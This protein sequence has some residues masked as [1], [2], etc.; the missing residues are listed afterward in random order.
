MFWRYYLQHFT[1]M[2]DNGVIPDGIEDVL[3]LVEDYD[4]TTLDEARVQALRAINDFGLRVCLGFR[5]GASIGSAAEW[6]DVDMWIEHADGLVRAWAINRELGQLGVGYEHEVDRRRFGFD[7]EGYQP[8]GQEA[9]V[10]VMATVGVDEAAMR[11][12]MQPLL[13][14]VRT[15]G[16][17]PMI[18][19]A[20]ESENLVIRLIFEASGGQGEL[21]TET[22]FTHGR[23]IYADGPVAVAEERA[24]LMELSAY[25]LSRYPQ[26]QIRPVISDDAVRFWGRTDNVVAS[27][28]RMAALPPWIIDSVRTD[29]S[30]IGTQGWIDGTYLSSLNDAA[31]AWGL[32][33]YAEV[34]A[35]NAIGGD[36]Q[37]HTFSSTGSIS[38]TPSRSVVRD[39][40]LELVA[41]DAYTWGLLVVQDNG[42]GTW[43]SYG[44]PELPTN[45]WTILVDITIPLVCPA[46]CPIVGATTATQWAWL[47][48]YDE[49][50]G[51]VVLDVAYPAAP[52]VTTLN[53]VTAQPG[54]SVRVLIGRNGTTEWRH[55]ASKTVVGGFTGNATNVMRFGLAGPRQSPITT[56]YEQFVGL[57][58]RKNPTMWDRF[59]S[60]S[61]ASWILA[62]ASRVFPFGWDYGV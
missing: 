51:Q 60:D 57:V 3:L 44:V 33:K 22:T 23:H 45:T 25:L 59:I 16:V 4:Q 6:A 11:I 37:L 29:R 12:I 55:G 26:A 50:A 35:R 40:G 15:L 2:L 52:N 62:D 27:I 54:D 49:V 7:C 43:S 13:T 34:P 42:N 53:V 46:F 18:H 39:D 56:P 1:T 31:Y 21:W 28:A 58:L 17:M 61:E 32:G 19:P 20:V 36:I 10:E 24:E 38:V 14:A 48:R 8:P 41:D 47:C 30:Y 5:F 9:T